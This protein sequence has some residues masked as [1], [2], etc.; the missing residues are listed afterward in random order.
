MPCTALVCIPQTMALVCFLKSVV[1][2]ATEKTGLECSTQE[3][4]MSTCTSILKTKHKIKH[5]G[6]EV[7]EGG[8][9]QRISKAVTGKEVDDGTAGRKRK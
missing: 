7:R 5:T 6:R 1:A 8:R 4:G 3:V 9:A 2:L